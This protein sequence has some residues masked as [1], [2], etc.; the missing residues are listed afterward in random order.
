M[1]NPFEEE[2]SSFEN[3]FESQNQTEDVVIYR[4]GEQKN[5]EPY[6]K[7]PRDSTNSNNPVSSEFHQ[8]NN[9][10]MNIYESPVKEVDQNLESYDIGNSSTTIFDVRTRKVKLSLVIEDNTPFKDIKKDDVENDKTLKNTQ[11]SLNDLAEKD[12][13]SEN[14]KFMI[15][16][17]TIAKDEIDVIME[18]CKKFH[19]DDKAVFQAFKRKTKGNSEITVL[20]P[21][22]K[23]SLRTEWIRGHNR[24]I[25]NI[26]NDHVESKNA[27]DMNY[28]SPQ[29]TNLM[30]NYRASSKYINNPLRRDIFKSINHSDNNPTGKKQKISETEAKICISGKKC[31]SFTDDYCKNYFNIPEILYSFNLYV[32]FLLNGTAIEKYCRRLNIACCSSKVIKNSKEDSKVNNEENAEDNHNEE[33]KEKWENLRQFLKLGLLALKTHDFKKCKTIDL[34]KSL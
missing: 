10:S 7:I 16:K 14:L 23:E 30:D 28:I 6:L 21:L 9:E 2:D 27:S 17:I 24:W 26:L 25:K 5:P 32:D 34:T 31:K 4:C 12:N 29:D 11:E 1:E 33:C 3:Y 15:R 20:M 8:E 22:K 18:N 13:K 19:L